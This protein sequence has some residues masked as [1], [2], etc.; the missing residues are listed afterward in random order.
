MSNKNPAKSPLSARSILGHCP[1]FTTP[2]AWYRVTALSSVL[3][4]QVSSA[5][6]RIR[7]TAIFKL[8]FSFSPESSFVF[9]LEKAGII[10]LFSARTSVTANNRIIAE[11]IPASKVSV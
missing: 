2:F 6:K 1:I 11:R 3:K 5:T 8:P 4:I 10:P 9:S 7:T